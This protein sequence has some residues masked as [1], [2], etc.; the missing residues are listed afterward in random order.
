VIGSREGS[1]PGMVGQR[2]IR[3]RWIDGPRGDAGT[4]EPEADAIV[5]Y[6]GNAVTVRRPRG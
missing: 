4:L 6:T 1:Y 5:R 3:V 2:E